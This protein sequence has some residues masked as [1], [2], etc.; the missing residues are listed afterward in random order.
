MINSYNAS[1]TTTTF[2]A[3]AIDELLKLS[4]Q[5]IAEKKRADDQLATALRDLVGPDSLRA[6]MWAARLGVPPLELLAVVD[7]REPPSGRFWE[8]CQAYF[9]QALKDFRASEDSARSPVGE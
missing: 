8:K 9:G 7:G 4:A 5:M 6:V 3:P 1:F 2:Q